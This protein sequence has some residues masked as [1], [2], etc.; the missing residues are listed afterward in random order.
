MVG[1][2]GSE[3]ATPSTPIM[4]VLDCIGY[5]RSCFS[6]NVLDFNIVKDRLY[7]ATTSSVLTSYKMPYGFADY[8]FGTSSA[9]LISPAALRACRVSGP[10]CRVLKPGMP[11]GKGKLGLF[12]SCRVSR[13]K[14]SSLNTAFT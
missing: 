8:S 13:E 11:S 6:E 10:R 5:I 2:S 3:T 9:C 14:S 4:I 1:P 7:V 12:S